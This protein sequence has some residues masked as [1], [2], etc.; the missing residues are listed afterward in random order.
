[1]VA[2][3]KGEDRAGVVLPVDA[4][5]LSNKSASG[6]LSVVSAGS[7]GSFR[8]A[9]KELGAPAHSNCGIFI[10]YSKNLEVPY[11]GPW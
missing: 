1:V 5:V 9:A 10:G 7:S 11:C 4:G 3:T 6:L 8:F 2:I